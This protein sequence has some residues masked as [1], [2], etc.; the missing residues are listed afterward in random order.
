MKTYYQALLAAIT[1]ILGQDGTPLFKHVAIFNNQLIREDDKQGY[2]FASPF[3][4]IEIVA[5][6]A[7]KQLGNGNQFYDPL[8]VRFHIGHFQLDAQDGTLDQDLNVFDLTQA[9]FLAMQKFKAEGA[10]VLVRMQENQNFDHTGMYLFLQDYITNYIDN[11][12]SQPIGGVSQTATL[13]IDESNTNTQEPQN[14]P[15]VYNG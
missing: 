14:N 11:S 7:I 9:T 2:T 5:P 13:E 3:N 10:G 4:L 8:I 15:H 1:A 6:S 12:A